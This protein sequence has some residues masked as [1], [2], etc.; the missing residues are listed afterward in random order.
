MYN[1][2]C[3]NIFSNSTNTITSAMSSLQM[4]AIARLTLLV[5]MIFALSSAKI[6]R[7]EEERKLSDRV[8]GIEFCSVCNHTSAECVANTTSMPF[9]GSLIDSITS[10]SLEFSPST[11]ENKTVT[12]DLLS[13]FKLLTKLKLTGNFIAI[14]AGSFDH[15]V[16]LQTLEIFDTMIEHLPPML[17]QNSDQLKTFKLRRNQ[18]KQF[19]FDTFSTVEY[20]MEFLIA[21]NQ[22]IVM[23]LDCEVD[24]AYARFPSRYNELYRNITSLSLVGIEINSSS[25]TSGISPE[26]FK[27]FTNVKVL[28][29]SYSNFFVNA[30]THSTLLSSLD[31][32]T[33]LRANGLRPFK[34][35]PELATQFF[36]SLP[37]NLRDV[38][39][40]NWESLD[41][42]NES[43]VYTN[44][45]LQPLSNLTRLEALS[46]RYNDFGFGLRLDA[47]ILPS[48]KRLKE[49]DLGFCGFSSIYNFTDVN[50]P[51]LEELL[52]DGNPLGSRQYSTSGS[53]GN[54]VSS[55]VKRLN[56]AQASIWSNSLVNFDI[57]SILEGFPNLTHFNLSDN[58]LRVP[59]IIRRTSFGPTTYKITH[60]DLSNNVISNT[61]SL[62]ETEDNPSSICSQLHFLKTIVLSTNFLEEIQEMCDRIEHLNLADNR[63]TNDSSKLGV[64]GD[65]KELKSLDLSMNR[66]KDVPKFVASLTQLE[67]INLRENILYELSEDA[68][69][70]NKRLTKVDLGLNY[71]STIS[72]KAFKHMSSLNQLSLRDNHIATFPEDFLKFIDDSESV[73]M[74]YLDANPIDCRC[75]RKYFQTWV[76]NTEK[77]KDA[78]MKNLICSSPSVHT[79]KHVY[80]YEED[81][82]DCYYKYPLITV[83]S[84]LTAAA[85]GILLAIPCHKYFWYIKHLRLVLL[86]IRENLKSIRLEHICEYDAYVSYN[87]EDHDDCDWVVNTLIPAIEKPDEDPSKVRTQDKAFT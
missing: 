53:E 9:L 71:L 60:L 27:P 16:K 58:Y 29:V 33:I 40:K 59:P 82:F 48:M 78:S 45:V 47:S 21:N 15:L 85:V 57:G 55:T 7:N 84:V 2:L 28:D 62:S 73:E 52:L 42:A 69:K 35:C 12:Y 83:V 56:L 20:G 30:S 39:F 5:L 79:G 61:K 13:R 86:A 32:L 34:F 67:E 37:K 75:S 87:R 1:Y 54:L 3:R 81:E 23:A 19:P 18:L 11:K 31:Q 38:S 64:L 25:C 63:L 8:C 72:V 17:L 41:P 76:Q 51:V 14:E 68:F 26:F 80:D 36:E 43:C 6:S 77:I 70:N 46:F 65:L 50:F 66:M 74:V 49:L 24:G 44:H 4:A 22:P 10:L